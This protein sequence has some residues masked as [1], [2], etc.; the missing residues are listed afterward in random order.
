MINEKID[1]TLDF[2][3][4][5]PKFLFS[6]LKKYFLHIT[7]FVTLISTLVYLG[8]LNL[9]KKYRS[10]AKIVIEP[11]EKNIVNIQEYSNFNNTNRINNQIAIFK[12]DQVLEYIIQDKENSKKFEMFFAENN[13]N[14][15][16]KLFNKKKTFNTKSLKSILSSSIQISNIRNS[17]ILDLSFISTNP[18]VAKLA[19]DRIINSY[20]RYE[21]DSKIQITNYANEKITER[22][23]ILVKEMDIAQKKLSKYKKENGLVDT[24]NVKQLKINEIQTISKRI[25]EAKQKYQN[26]QN[27]L[28]SIKVADGDLD[29]LLAIND[30]NTRKDI[31]DIKDLLS[32]NES[33][34]Q[35]LSLIYTDQ[36]PKIIQAK[37]QKKNLKKQLKKILDTNIEQKAFELSNLNSFIKLSEREMDKVTSE[38]R[39]IEEKE[40]GMLKFTR[41]LESS[42]NLYQSFLQRVKETNE[43]QNLQISKLKILES[44]NLPG[45]H[46]YPS[47]KKNSFIAF[48]ISFFGIFALLFF[49][50]MNSSALRNTDAIESLNILQLGVLPRV[51][52]IKENFDIIQLFSSDNESHFAESIR[53]SRAIIESKFNKNSSFLITSSNPSEG[54]TT[55]AFNLALSLEKSNKV[56]FIEGD[57]RRPTVLNRFVGIQSKKFGLGEIISGKSELNEVIHEIPG[58]NLNI[59]TSGD[60]KIDMSDVVSKDQLKKFFD[61]LK[62][63]YEYVIIDS[64]PVQPVSDTLILAQSVDNNFFIIRADETTTGSLM[65]SIKKIKSVGAKID[66]IVLNDVDTSKGSY[67]Y[68]NYYQNYYGAYQKT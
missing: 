30:L 46:F 65:S 50:E 49:K 17:D 54:K 8:S 2:I 67:G 9:D 52:K 66:G 44:P 31:T 37:D 22:L 59:I 18:R 33:N 23:Q 43:A 62:I 1:K 40:S 48:I 56:L 3:D 10:S 45:S 64:P 55:F 14:L 6:I 5:D 26:Q 29:A 53:S 20:Q 19:L 11:D 13:Q 25:I 60:V 41:E 21:I 39:D 24:G 58:T 32:S 15:V 4:L 57:L 47:P 7:I 27:D 36:H 38:L 42:K 61:T 12:S 68:Y 35:S 16:Q 28:L 34:I 51:E 63:E